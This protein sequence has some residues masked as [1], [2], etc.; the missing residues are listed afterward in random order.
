MSTPNKYKPG[1]NTPKA[2]RVKDDEMSDTQ[3]SQILT[4]LRAHLYNNPEKLKAG[5]GHKLR[6]R[7]KRK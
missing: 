1:R 3:T 2:E 6:G 4:K 7:K 5:F